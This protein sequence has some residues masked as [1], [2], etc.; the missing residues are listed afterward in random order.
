MV[1]TPANAKKAVPVI[2]LVNFGGGPPPP[3]GT[4]ARGPA[5]NPHAIR[6][7][8]A[9][10]LARGWGYATVGYGD[11]QP[12]RANTAGEAVMAH[13]GNGGRIE[14]RRRPTT[15]ARSACGRGA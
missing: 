14:G 10:I 11:I 13:G 15:G 8:A 6:R 1:T 5:F 4:T 2:L 3:P 12:D 9:D 7:L